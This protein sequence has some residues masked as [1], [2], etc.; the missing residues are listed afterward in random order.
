MTGNNKNNKPTVGILKESL[1]LGGTERSAANTSRLLEKYYDLHLILYNGKDVKYQ[2]GGNLIDIKAPPMKSVLGKVINSFIRYLRV[3]KVVKQK[4]IDI[5]YEFITIGNMLSYVS[6]KDTK[7]IISARDFGKM[8][9]DTDMF[10]KALSKASGMI[11]NSEYTK[12]YYLSKYPEDK[13]KVFTVYNVI[14]S[15]EIARQSTEEPEKEFLEFVERH[16]KVISVVGRFCKEKGFEFML[17]SFAKA[18]E[19]TDLGRVMIC[20]GAYKEKYLELID[21]LGVEDRVYFTGFQNNPYKYMAKSDIFVLSSLSEGFPNVVAEAMSLG[22]P[23]IASNC[24][25]GPAEIL[26]NDC[27]YEAVIDNYV[28]CDYG[29]ITPRMTATDNENAISS[30]ADAIVYLAND[31]ELLKKYSQLSKQRSLEY[32]PEVAAQ[33]FRKIFD[34]LV[35]G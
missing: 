16:S 18:S 35:D 20:D 17:E 22:L 29:I 2:Y 13:D 31:E 23:V 34:K 21:K 3:K 11:C 4:N 6:Y 30:L 24:Y 7:R 9:R 14:D 12:D 25:S 27:D 1:C 5:L 33:K 26:R 15:K 8:Q 10:N 32:S 19:T 28:E